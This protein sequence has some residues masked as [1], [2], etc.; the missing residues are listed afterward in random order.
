MADGAFPEDNYIK[1]HAK[2]G[3]RAK[4]RVYIPAQLRAGKAAFGHFEGRLNE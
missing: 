1:Y 4:R 2:S 3:A